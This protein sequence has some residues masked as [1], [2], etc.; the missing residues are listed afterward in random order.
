[1]TNKHVL[2]ELSAYIDGA[3]D[4][5]GRVTRHLQ[6]C[7]DC[8]RRHLELLKIGAHIRDEQ[9]PVVS[10]DFTERVLAG[11]A[12]HPQRAG[13]SSWIRPAFVAG[14]SLAALFTLVAL[15]AIL[16][17]QERSRVPEASPAAARGMDVLLESDTSLAA[18]D[19]LLEEGLWPDIYPA[20][21]ADAEPE[22]A[23]TVDDLIEGLAALP[24]NGETAEPWYGDDDL[25]SVME[26]LAEVDATVLNELLKTHWD[27]V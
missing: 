1:M 4:D 25:V 16:A 2:D 10:A 12:D 8:A 9:P 19:R 3:S 26:A 21:E 11:I 17:T 6:S 24:D 20:D 22:S 15:G 23:P 27:N 5:L 7:P 14:A 13:R 18:L